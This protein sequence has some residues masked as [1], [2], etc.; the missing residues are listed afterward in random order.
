MSCYGRAGSLACAYFRH[1]GGIEL[2]FSVYGQF[3]SHFFCYFSGFHYLVHHFM[4]GRTFGGEAEHGHSRLFKS[5]NGFCCRSRAYCYL[6]QLVRIG[7]GSHG[8]IAYDEHSAFAVFGSLCYHEHCSRYAC[9]ARSGLD[10]LQRRT[11]HIACGVA[12]SCQ[13]SVGITVL[14]HEASQIER[15]AHQLFGFF[16]RHAFLLS[17]FKQQ[18]CVFPA[19]G[20]VVRVDYFGFVYVV[21]TQP[22]CFRHDF[23]R[24]SEQD[25]PGNAFGQ[26]PVGRTEC[27][28]FCA[29]GQDYALRVGFGAFDNTFN[30]THF[31]GFLSFH[32][33]NSVTKIIVFL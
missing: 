21:Q 22:F 27:P 24:I 3:R 16:H 10:Y 33:C 5:C 6:C 25:E 11:Q 15:V 18:L 4:F 28:F 29:F 19:V 7:C 8:H 12:C 26:S 20:V 31:F 32:L 23:F 13:L 1:E 30:D 2:Q 17:Q 14:Y 9:Y